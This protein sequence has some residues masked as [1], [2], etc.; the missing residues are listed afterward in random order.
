ML[1]TRLEMLA[2]K[3]TVGCVCVCG[4][5][6]SRPRIFPIVIFP[7]ALCSCSRAAV[8]S[9]VPSTK[10]IPRKTGQPPKDLC[11]PA[12]IE[13][14]SGLC[15]GLV[16]PCARVG[17]G[18]NETNACGCNKIWYSVVDCVAF[19]GGPS[20]TNMSGG[21]EQVIERISKLQKG[22]LGVCGGKGCICCARTWV[23]H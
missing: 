23:L 17:C 7:I 10:S 20:D 12:W 11:A 6:A 8:D 13:A 9:H 22:K 3:A 1:P 5:G 16:R 2:T 15:S 19:K 4:G 21:K 14:M 18:C